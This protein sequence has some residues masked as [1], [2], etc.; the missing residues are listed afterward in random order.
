MTGS[1][2]KLLSSDIEL[3]FDA[4]QLKVTLIVKPQSHRL[5]IGQKFAEMFLYIQIFL[6]LSIWFA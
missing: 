3:K 6:W 4:F 5:L 1:D 2:F